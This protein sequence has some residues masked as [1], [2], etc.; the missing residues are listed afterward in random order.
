M[1][2]YLDHFAAHAERFMPKQRKPR[3][4]KVVTSDADAPL[5]P[6]AMEQAQ[7]DKGTLL[8]SFKRTKKAEHEAMLAS[9][10][11]AAYGRMMEIVKRLPDSA[12]ELVKNLGKGWIN[13]LSAKQKDTVLSMI[14]AR[15][16]RVREMDGRT[17]FDDPLPGEP[18]NL[19][20]ICRKIIQGF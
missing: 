3:A 14:S 2:D 4:P 1:S 8:A 11:G 17:P 10:H 20:I 7:R 5:K 9:E 15:I 19:F 12:V 13:A 6:T 18:D 16:I